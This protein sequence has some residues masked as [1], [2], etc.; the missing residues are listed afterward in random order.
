MVIFN[1][2]VKLPKG[3][4]CPSWTSITGPRKDDF[5]RKKSSDLTCP[6]PRIMVRWQGNIPKWHYFILSH[7]ISSYFILFPVISCYFK[8]V[9]D[10]NSPD[11][12]HVENMSMSSA[13][14]PP[15]F[16]QA[17]F[18]PAL[19]EKTR[20]GQVCLEKK[21]PRPRDV[22]GERIPLVRSPNR[23]RKT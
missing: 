8:L 10:W 20:P 17:E 18:R 3:I 12:S 5:F 15:F 23:P 13:E 6:S 9:N 16:R 19:T 7:L 22:G 2:Y 14:P 4:Q 11:F 21:A 1:S